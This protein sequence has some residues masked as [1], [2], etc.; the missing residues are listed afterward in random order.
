MEG[1]RHLLLYDGVCG[2]CNWL[3]QVVLDHDPGGRFHYAALQSD[4]ARDTLARYGASAAALDSVYVIENYR[5]AAPRLLSRGEAALFLFRHFGGA[6]RVLNVLR[7]LPSPVLDWGYRLVARHRYRL[8][9]KY[10]TCPL[11]DPAVRARFIDQHEASD[12]LRPAPK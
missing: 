12:A 7:V 11:P 1:I 5:D 3:V 8:F 10:D 2:L 6:W 4:T 9:G